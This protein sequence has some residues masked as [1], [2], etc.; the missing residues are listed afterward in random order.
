MPFLL[1]LWNSPTLTTWGSFGARSLGLVIVL[2]LVLKKFTTAEVALWQVFSTLINLQILAETGLGTTFS[3][4][5]AYAMGGAIEL[6]NSQT[7]LSVSGALEVVMQGT[8][9]L[10]EII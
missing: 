5:V 7:E 2:P 6:E 1:R 8:R 10:T 4:L 9:I 3:R